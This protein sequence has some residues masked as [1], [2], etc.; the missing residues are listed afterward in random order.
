[1]WVSR[2]GE[3]HEDGQSAVLNFVKCHTLLL[4]QMPAWCIM[5]INTAS[6]NTLFS[7]V[8]QLIYKLCCYGLLSIH[9]ETSGNVTLSS[10]TCCLK[11]PLSVNFY[12]PLERI[13]C[14]P[15]ICCVPFV[16][17]EVLTLKIL[18]K[19]F[20]QFPHLHAIVHVF[21]WGFSF[22]LHWVIAPHRLCVSLMIFYSTTSYAEMICN[23]G[24]LIEENALTMW[25]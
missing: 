10:V 22:Q 1:M 19:W 11:R 12:G 15:N 14:F 24:V 8:I 21:S 4:Y 16:R 6:T 9:K 23:D 20:H 13:S 7:V 5:Q 18:V 17:D 25:E 2:F 3:I